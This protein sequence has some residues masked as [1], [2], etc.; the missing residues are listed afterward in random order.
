M[1]QKSECCSQHLKGKRP[2]HFAG[3]LIKIDATDPFKEG[4]DRLWEV[5]DLF[6]FINYIV[7]VHILA[8]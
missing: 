6:F 2:I 4:L 1:E 5:I 8:V 7:N 3:V